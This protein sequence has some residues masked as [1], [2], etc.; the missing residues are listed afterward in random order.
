MTAP[1]IIGSATLFLGDCLDVLQTLPDNSVDSIVTD[2][3]YGL[4]FMGKRWDYDVPSVEIWAEC[5]RV[6]KPGGH[7]LA[8]AGTRTYHRMTVR[9]E[10]AGFEIRD[11]VAWV[12]GSGFPKSLDIS[13]AIDRMAGAEREVVGRSQWANRTPNGCAGI[14]GNLFPKDKTSTAPATPAAQEWAG[15]GTALKPAHEPICLARKPLAGTVA[16]NVLAWGVGGLNV[17]GCRVLKDA[18]EESGWSKSGS[19]ASENRSM[20]GA[21]YQRLPKPDAAGRWPANFIHDGSA[22]VVGLFP[23][24]T[25][26]QPG[27]STRNNSRGFSGIG[28]SGLNKMIPRTGFCDTGSAARFFYTAKASKAD[29]DDGCDE[30]EEKARH[31]LSGGRCIAEGRTEANGKGSGRNHHPTVKPLDLMRYL[32]RL[33]TPPGG[34]ALDP[35]MGSGSTGKAAYPEGFQFLGIERDPEYFAIACRRIAA[36]QR[37]PD[38]FTHTDPDPTPA[39]APPRAEQTALF[40]AA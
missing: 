8:F 20:S 24:T 5:L 3:P 35:F 30:W 7:L 39:A 2:P 23:E 31:T 15:W 13:K 19:N 12:Y 1:I 38:I 25:S 33:V 16:E 22:E 29:R 4:A 14:R 32:L 40:D 28:N 11:M 6:L 18:G 26:G 36:A 37:Q 21:N 34:L 17:E 27:N 9:I 10:D